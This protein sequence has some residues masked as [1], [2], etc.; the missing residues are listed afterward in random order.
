MWELDHKEGWAPKDWC[1]WTVVLEEIL[2]SSLDCKEIQPVN[3]KGNQSWIFIERTDA[4]AETPVLWPPDT[5]SWL[6]RK[7]MGVR[8]DCGGWKKLRGAKEILEVDWFLKRFA[9][10]KEERGHGAVARSTGKVVC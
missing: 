3:P 4:E 8:A 9:W 7:V 5:K 2:E 6:I 1:F 10:E